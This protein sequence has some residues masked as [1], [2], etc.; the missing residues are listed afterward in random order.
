MVL[1]SDDTDDVSK[2]NDALEE[3]DRNWYLGMESEN[4]WRHAVLQETP[5]LFCI[6]SVDTA[7][8]TGRYPNQLPNWLTLIGPGGG[9]GY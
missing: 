3:I 8:A 4:Q 6:N 7:S 2:L 5:F 1:L 9:G